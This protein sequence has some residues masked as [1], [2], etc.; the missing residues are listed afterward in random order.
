[1][2][3]TEGKAMSKG[4]PR[5]SRISGLFNV[6]KPGGMTSHDVVGALRRASG[7]RRIG[8][9]GTLDPMATGVLLVCMGQA[10]RLSEYLMAGRKSYAADIRLGASTDTDD[11]DGEI[12]AEADASGV[13]RD[14]IER[15]LPA[16]RGE[17]A[18]VPPMYSAIKRDGVALHKL[19][20]QGVALELEPRP[21]TIYALDVAAWQPPVLS[22]AVTCSKG[23]YIRALAR[24]LGQA[25]GCGAHL[26]RLTRTASGPFTLE[27]AAPLDALVASLR[28]GSWERYLISMD[29]ALAR[30]PGRTMGAEEAAR[31]QQGQQ[32]ALPGADTAAELLK[33]YAPEGALLALLRYDEGTR[34]WQPDKVFA[35]NG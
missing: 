1:L 31:I 24:D 9:A 18:Q 23:T 2:C 4:T 19:A 15:A 11:A 29:A 12:V 5:E 16:F 27:Q 34:R 17:I 10:T 28:E 3:H 25:L 13:T 8:H 7:E 26:T 35:T 32:V 14:Q 22:V 6:D 20:R 30:Y 33:A 21:V